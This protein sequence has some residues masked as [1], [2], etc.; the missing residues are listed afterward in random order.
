MIPYSLNRGRGGFN[1]YLKKVIVRPYEEHSGSFSIIK[2]LRKALYINNTIISFVF[3][4]MIVIPVFIF[5]ESHNYLDIKNKKTSLKVN[6]IQKYENTQAP[7]KQPVKKREEKPKPS[8][9]KIT[10]KKNKVQKKKASRPKQAKAKSKSKPK[11]LVLK[12]PDKVSSTLNSQLNKFKKK[13]K[14]KIF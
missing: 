2:V 3:S 4:A 11:S 12:M 14:K 9:K 13:K 7:R 5:I 1:I 8:K 6:V 10:A